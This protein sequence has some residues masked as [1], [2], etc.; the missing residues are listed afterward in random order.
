MTRAHAEGAPP[1]DRYEETEI[2]SPV[3]MLKIRYRGD[4][5]RS[6]DFLRDSPSSKPR[7][8]VTRQSSYPPGSPPSQL[9]AYFSGELRDFQLK[10]DLEGAS[11]F[12]RSVWNALLRIPYGE[13]LTYGQLA[14]EIGR[15]GAA[16]AVGGAAHRNPIALIIPCHR[17]VGANGDLTGFGPGIDK[18]AWLLEHE[19]KHA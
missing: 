1:P 16:R 17:L 11:E 6:L 14:R 19:R 18:K 9:E 7:A 8:K 3:G 13:Q 10:V 4:Q 12:D 2:S 15:P 5:V